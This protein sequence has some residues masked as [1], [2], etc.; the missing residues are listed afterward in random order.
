MKLQKITLYSALILSIVT[1]LYSSDAKE[2]DKIQYNAI[3]GNGALSINLATGSPG[4]L[5][6]LKALSDPFCEKNNCTVKWIKMGSGAAL[7]ALK[8]GKVQMVLVH[9][10]EAEKKAVKDGWATM[11]MLIGG[12]EFFI[13][14]PESDPA[15]IRSTKSVIEAYQK[16]AS[17]KCRFY[18]RGD[19][20]G[21]HKKEL[22]IWKEAGVSPESN[23][24]IITHDF[25]GPTLMR[26]EREGGYFMTDSSTYYAKRSEI[27]KLNVLFKGDPILVNLYHALS[28]PEGM[29][30]KDTYGIVTD[31]IKFIISEKGQEIISAYGKEEY[32]FSIYMTA[33]QVDKFED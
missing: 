9:A 10:P 31:F 15:G 7:N 33:D 23:W 1:I 18:S 29:I 12:N 19:N 3:Y 32:G 27:K 20:S 26:A 13:V 24:Y 5:G 25:M 21:T 8:E 30:S 17:M 11:R 16:I 22:M 14:G 4:S 6:L 2:S 28:A